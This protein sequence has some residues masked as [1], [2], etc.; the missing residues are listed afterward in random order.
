MKRLRILVVMLKEFVPPQSLE[1]CPEKEM[2]RFKTEWDVLA[3]LQRLGHDVRPLGV[4][5][6]LGVI[7]TQLQEYEPHVAFNLLEEFGGVSWYSHYVVSFL[8][9]MHQRYT[10]CNPRGLMLSQDKALSKKILAYHRIRVPDFAVFAMKRKVRRP[11]KLRFPLLVKSITEQG[12]VGIAHASLVTNDDKLR[13]RVEFVHE[14]LFTD[15][16]A[17]E[18]IEG[19]E[20]YV[21]VMGHYRLELLPI[22]EMYF[23]NLAD[24]AP[25]IATERLKWDVDYQERR[26]VSTRAAGDLPPTVQDDVVRICRRLYKVLHLSGYARVDLRVTADGRVYV[27][28]ANPNP[29]LANGEDFAASAAHTGYTYEKLLQRIVDLGMNYRAAW[30]MWY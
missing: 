16:I 2:A 20:L 15:A 14:Q 3:G 9:L 8:E 23:E 28:E 1:G 22:W 26:G 10:G 19:R 6:D 25:R 7:R 11:A 17:E 4:T 18:Y 29:Q 30:Q 24:G 13:E 21:G 12:S 27:L 5:D